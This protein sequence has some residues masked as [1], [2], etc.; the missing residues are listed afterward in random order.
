MGRMHYVEA[1]WPARIGPSTPLWMCVFLAGHPFQLLTLPA[2]PWWTAPWL[3]L[4]LLRWCMEGLDSEV[5]LVYFSAFQISGSSFFPSSLASPAGVGAG[6]SEVRS[7]WILV[8]GQYL[9]G[10]QGSLAT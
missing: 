8:V 6:V 10:T 4:L 7:I 1:T 3:P 5:A 9:L 2:T